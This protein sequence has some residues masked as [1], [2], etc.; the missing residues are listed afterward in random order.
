VD[1]LRL[2]TKSAE[3]SIMPEPTNCGPAA[4]GGIA[5]RLRSQKN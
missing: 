3:M 1:E 2:G 5:M 4:I